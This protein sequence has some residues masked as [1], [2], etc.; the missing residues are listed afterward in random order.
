MSTIPEFRDLLAFLNEDVEAALPANGDTI[1]NWTMETFYNE[2]QQVKQAVQS[3]ASKIHFT[4][5]LWTSSNSLALLG[6]IAHY[7]TE[8]GQLCQSVLALRELEGQHT[9]ENQAQLIM[10]IIIEYGIVSKVGYFMMDNAENNET[11]MRALSTSKDILQFSINSNKVGLLTQFDI[12]YDAS[13]HRL[14]CNGHI[15]NLAAQAFLFSSDEDSLSKLNNTASSI[16]SQLEMDTWRRKGPLGKLHNIVVYIQ[17][18]PQRRAAFQKLSQGRHLIRDNKTRWNSWYT[19]IG[20]A[21]DE[22]VRPAIELYCHQNQADMAEDILSIHD[23]ENLEN[24]YTFLLD[25]YEV[26]LA[27]E[28]RSTT[29]EQVLPSMDYLLEKLESGKTTYAADPFM[30]PCINS[31]WAKLDKYYGLTERSSVYIAA[32]VLI[33]SQKWTYFE[34]NWDLDWV[35][36][37]KKAVQELWQS[38]YRSTEVIIPSSEPQPV[39][40]GF[41]KWRAEKARQAPITVEYTRYCQ[42]VC[43]PIEVE[44]MAWWLES[45][46]RATYPNLSVMALDILSIPA[47]SAEPERL[48]SGAGITVTERRNRLGAESIEALE[49]LKSW[50]GNHVGGWLDY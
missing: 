35:I 24:I 43:C 9:G 14:R 42:V 16:P 18:S 40:T 19:M 37:G 47:M 27:N 1:R 48:F 28:G 13:H 49:C 50:L 21:I 25:F 4:V 12:T 34:D 29:L 46:Q 11:M 15:I 36:A 33:P 7:F 44:S 45:T 30:I 2:Q 23:W 32:M 20:C 38:Q 5:D 3:A 41:A 26:T 39:K 17:R 22:K 31:G 6:M 8:N 10:K